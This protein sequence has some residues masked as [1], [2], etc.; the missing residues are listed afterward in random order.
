MFFTSNVSGIYGGDCTIMAGSIDELNLEK[1]T[2][3]L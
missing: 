2:I 3:L 1:E